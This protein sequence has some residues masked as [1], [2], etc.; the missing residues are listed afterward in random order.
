MMLWN[1][2]HAK[3]YQNYQKTKWKAETE[4]F[5]ILLISINSIQ[6]TIQKIMINLFN[7]L[8]KC[9]VTLLQRESYWSDND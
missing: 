4:Y 6:M 3:Y 7:Y 8:S 2:D 9:S 1:T 5:F